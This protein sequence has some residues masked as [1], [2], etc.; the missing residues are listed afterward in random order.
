MKSEWKRLYNE[1]T[2]G[3]R[4]SDLLVDQLVEQNVNVLFGL[5]A[6]SI[7]ALFDGAR[8][9]P[10][11]RTVTCRHETGGA[12]MAAAYGKICERPAAVTATNGPGVTHLPIGA[13]DA[14][15][16]QAPMVIIPGAAPDCTLGTNGFQ[17]VDGQRLLTPWTVTSMR[18]ATA[19]GFR[20]LSMLISRSRRENRPVAF[21]LAS[22]ALSAPVKRG[23][24]RG[25]LPSVC[26]SWSSPVTDIAEAAR[27]V[28]SSSRACVLVGDTRG[29]SAD[30]IS[31]VH[32]L[33]LLAPSGIQAKGW[34]MVPPERRL[35]TSVSSN[36]ALSDADILIVVGAL[37]EEVIQLSST[38]R[39]VHLTPKPAGLP[40]SDHYISVCGD[41]VHDLWNEIGHIPSPPATKNPGDFPNFSL[42]DQAI[43]A[44]ATVCIEGRDTLDLALHCVSEKNRC[45][46]STFRA[47]TLGYAIPAAVAATVARPGFPA[48]AIVDGPGWLEGQAELLSARKHGLPVSVVLLANGTAEEES[49]SLQARALGLNVVDPAEQVELPPANA[50]L[51]CNIAPRGKIPTVVDAEPDKEAPRPYVEGHAMGVV[52]AAKDSG[53]PGILEVQDEQELLRVLNPLYDALFDNVPLVLVTW[54]GSRYRSTDTLLNEVATVTYN[55]LPADRCRLIESARQ[56]AKRNRSVILVRILTTVSNPEAEISNSRW[57]LGGIHAKPRQV[58]LRTSAELLM[59]AKSPVIVCGGGSQ[60]ARELIHALSERLSAPVVG[61]MSAGFVDDLPSYCGYIGSSGHKAANFAAASADVILVLG[62]SNRGAAFDF[63][64]SSRKA[65]DVNADIEVLTHRSMHLSIH[66]NCEDYLRQLLENCTESRKA[67]GYEVV[68]KQASWWKAAG[69]RPTLNG[70]LRP[71]YVVRELSRAAEAHEGASFAGDV[72]INTL[73]LFRFHRRHKDTLWTRNFATMGFALPAAVQRATNTGN[74]SIAV[75][76]D[77]GMGMAMPGLSP[78]PTKNV[79]VLCVVLDN[80][81]LAAI[82]YEQEILGWP[83]YESGFTNPDFAKV[84]QAHNW[85]GVTVSTPAELNSEIDRFFSQPTPTVLNVLCSKDEP[86]MPAK[87]PSLTQVAAASVAWVRQGKKGLNSAV[88]AV[89]GLGER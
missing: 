67:E 13:R 77:G 74:V 59:S 75:T 34:S 5:P 40:H 55:G 4:G 29:L 33:G 64:D 38:K 60:G 62:V 78:A 3:C 69:T 11:I 76:G 73:W 89:R 51:V 61:T 46:T 9:N 7:N 84:A 19:E 10:G 43:P 86:P 80:A 82:R 50:A 66:S 88:H 47:Q 68:E 35:R 72:G 6:D 87:S 1:I 25:E 53:V 49:L 70:M 24:K 71:S 12:L 52:A 58:D 20:R 15:L 65:I 45:F 48:V 17:D 30:S 37:P 36:E 81:G 31:G 63:F 26:E 23:T 2:G 16:D 41:S 18:G 83:E 27:W 85:F 54:E 21:C 8:R 39:V 42:I 32:A 44:D 14:W 28:Q 79:P 22:D 56:V 57:C